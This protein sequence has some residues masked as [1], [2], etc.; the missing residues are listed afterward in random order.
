MPS[1][2]KNKAA[3]DQAQLNVDYTRIIAPCNGTVISKNVEVGQ[4]VAASLQAPTLFQIAEDLTQM[5]V[6]ASIDEADV[7]VVKENQ[8]ATFTVDAY[9]TKSFKG[10]VSQV[11]FQPITT[12]N[13]VTYQGIIDVSNPELEL[14]PGMTANISFIV[15]EKTD[16][17]KVPN[18]ALRFKLDTTANNSSSTT[19]NGSQRT[20]MGKKSSGDKVNRGRV[21]VLDVAKKANPVEVKTGI[22]DSS[23][24]EII[25]PT[26][27]EGDEVVTG[28]ILQSASAAA[29]SSA[30]SRLFTGGRPPR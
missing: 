17:I 12:S 18:T 10:T 8:K 22:T 7:G 23:Y 19:A 25:D 16:V 20:R 9:P 4:T 2:S 24:T 5:Q 13:V 1:I 6:V 14:K 30:S 28:Y 11:R 27:K 26:L 15:S 21:Y 29:S 3:L